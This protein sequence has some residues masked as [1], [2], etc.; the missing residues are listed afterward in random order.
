MQP[1]ISAQDFPHLSA[2]IQY[3]LSGSPIN[4]RAILLLMFKGNVKAKEE[5][6]L[7][8]ALEGT[9]KLYNQKR[10]TL[11]PL[12]ILHPIRTAALLG[13]AE[14]PPVTI[15]LVTALLHD[16][17]EDFPEATHQPDSSDFPVYFLALQ[18]KIGITAANFLDEQVEHLTKKSG[19]PYFQYLG[20]LLK[21]AAERPELLRIKLADQLDNILDLRMDPYRPT[22]DMD[23]FHAIFCSLFVNGYQVPAAP[24]PHPQ[25]RKIDG[26]KRLYR[27][28]KTTVFLSMIRQSQMTLDDSSQKLFDA[29]ALAGT[30]EAQKI[31]LHICIYHFKDP[32]LQRRLLLKVMEYCQQGG[33]DHI[34]GKTN[35]CLDGLFQSYFDLAGEE[36]SKSLAQLYHDKTLMASAAVTFVGIFESFLNNPHFMIKGIMDSGI[37]AP[38]PQHDCP[39]EKG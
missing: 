36:R 24:H 21:H 33:I 27:L 29:L 11:G 18:K 5:S 7:L 13:M 15:D 38:H 10:R 31:L 28:F 35:H 1:L 39:G 26:A 22:A 9:W 17:N 2:L 3:Q 34:S 32:A 20:R 16:K 30:Q 37:T 12:A 25:Q 19:E 23:C 6:I 8:A 14:Q 4:W